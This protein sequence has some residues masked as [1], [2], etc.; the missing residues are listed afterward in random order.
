MQATQNSRL[1]W[2]LTTGS[3]TV[4]FGRIPFSVG[5]KRI[6]D[7]QY[8]LKYY[9]SR[10]LTGKRLYL[11]GTRKQGCTAHIELT[12]YVTYP[13]FQIPA[14]SMSKKKERKVKEEL[15]LELRKGIQSGEI[16]SVSKYF[17]SLPSDEAH[18]KCHPTGKEAGMAQRVH[19]SIIQK[20][21][22]LV[23]E[24]MVEPL[25]VQRHLKHY[26]Q[27]YLCA[28]ELP[29]SL[30]RAYY[31]DIQDIRNHINTA[32]RSLQLSVI[33]QENV[34]LKTNEWK[35]LSPDTKLFFRPYTENDSSSLTWIHQEL[36][37]QEVLL[38][39][40]NTISM[41]DATYKTT[42]YDLPLFFVCVK[43]NAGYCV[44][45]EFIVESESADSI[46]EAL[47]ILQGWNPEW[48]PA[49][50]MSDYSEA[51]MNAVESLFPGVKVYI[52]DF[53]REQAWERWVKDHKHNLTSSQAA[54]LLDLL[55]ACA[56]APSTAPDEQLPKDHY[57]QQAV[58]ALQG[59]EVW[60]G[61]GQV[62][63]WFSNTWLTVAEV[64]TLSLIFAHCYYM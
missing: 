62:Q 13:L 21:H 11:Q 32:K 19:P 49:F 30:D 44:V 35:E 1:F 8:G 26:V 6:L 41:I 57:F 14:E 25:E 10:E 46:K 3:R 15:L 20:I 47:S 55:R 38:R 37:Q 9:K 16:K 51:E 18:H 60:K 64:S 22:A 31:P 24:G 52:C 2:Q 48:K 33:D 63:H 27:H 36:W 45:A 5:E 29:D 17:V 61:N 58:I 28:S 59:S 4:E 23:L 53:H 54:D 34:L 12:E 50:F 7:C 43:T 42:K 39:Y 40:G 56:W